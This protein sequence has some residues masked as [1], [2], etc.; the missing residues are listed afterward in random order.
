MREGVGGGGKAAGS[1]FWP[2]QKH[3]GEP[4]PAS[5]HGC[6]R[7]H[8]RRCRAPLAI[9]SEAAVGIYSKLLQMYTTVL[10]CTVTTVYRREE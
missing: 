8:S 10:Y 7:T 3:E 1:A 4:E 2:G 9:R 6:G 5:L